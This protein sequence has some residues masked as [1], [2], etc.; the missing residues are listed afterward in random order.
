MEH[1]DR[2][3]DCEKA[4]QQLMKMNFVV[5][6]NIPSS[7][8]PLLLSEQEIKEQIMGLLKGEKKSSSLGQLV[9]DKNDLR[10]LLG[11]WSGILILLCG[12]VTLVSF[13]LAR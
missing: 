8:K 11:N 13:F 6:S 5:S 12:L 9:L 2:C 1:I 4:W 10:D 7:R 3:H